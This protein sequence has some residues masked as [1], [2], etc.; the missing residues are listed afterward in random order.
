MHKSNKEIFFEHVAQTSPSPL[1]VEI[2]KAEGIYLYGRDNKQYIDLV[3]GVS[4]SNVGHCNQAVV[5]AIQKQVSKYM[6][7]MVYGEMI[8]A[9]Q[10][11]YAQLLTQHL[12]ST[13]DSVYFVNSG[14]E[15]I[16]GALKL[17]KRVTGRAKVVAFEKAYHGGTHGALS[18]LGSETLKSA[19]R[20]LLPGVTHI[21]F[22]Q[23][24]DL[25]FIDTSTACVVVE[26][27]QAEAGII[28]PD[29][30]FLEA[31]H[32]RCAETGTLLIFDEVQTGFGRTGSLFAFEQYKVTPDILVLAKAMGGGMPLGGF[33]ASHTLMN[34]LTH[35]PML[36][37]ITT[38]GGHPVS[39]AAAL[40]A[41]NFIV[42]E[43]LAENARLRGEQFRELLQ[44]EKI[45]AVR[46]RGL[47]LAVDLDGIF[48]PDFM[49]HAAQC[50]LIIDPF[51]FHDNAFRIA[52]PLIIT[53]QEV[54]QTVNLIIHAL[55]TF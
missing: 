15:A 45:V 31:V 36:G 20:P 34:Q 18:L 24:E 41:L 19:F 11:E 48:I 50:G 44:H 29:A 3:S 21:R 9:P 33:V 46:G 32:Q 43:N 6:H 47:L 1:G 38:F 53:E 37:H 26:P 39:C 30:G 8:Q 10:V 13:L 28:M 55:D 14:S 7:L 35:N 4:V 17:A 52:P 22:N 2:D 12:P 51:L 42:E 54:E 27:I 49:H 40:A 16:E 25:T 23:F 5:S